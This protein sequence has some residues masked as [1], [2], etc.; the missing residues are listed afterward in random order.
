MAYD[1]K[2][3]I[4]IRCGKGYEARQ[5]DKLKLGKIECVESIPLFD[6]ETGHGIGMSYKTRKKHQYDF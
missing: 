6:K 3:A 4:C 1:D 5:E 2:Y